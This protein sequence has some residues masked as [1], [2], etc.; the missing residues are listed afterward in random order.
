AAPRHSGRA[1]CRRAARRARQ[2]RLK[3]VEH[4][5]RPWRC[6]WMK[7]SRWLQ[8]SADSVAWAAHGMPESP[9]DISRPGR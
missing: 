4:E 8:V 2:A 1:H 3:L 9:H 7:E 5:S 6:Q